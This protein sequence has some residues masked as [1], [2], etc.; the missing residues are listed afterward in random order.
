MNVLFRAVLWGQRS[1]KCF[2]LKLCFG[3]RHLQYFTQSCVLGTG[4]FSVLA[5]ACFED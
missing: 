2:V 3:D 4:I 5:E 1:V